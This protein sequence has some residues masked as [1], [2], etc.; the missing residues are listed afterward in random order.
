[1][2]ESVRLSPFSEGQLVPP[3]LELC[4]AGDSDYLECGSRNLGSPNFLANA[5]VNIKRGQGMLDF[6]DR[7]KVPPVLEPIRQ[8]RRRETSFWLCLERSRLAYYR[9]NDQAL[10]TICDAVDANAG[11]SALVE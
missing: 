9:G 1:M 6:L 2:D 4:I 11:C 5:D 8:F 7:V 10:R 3:Q